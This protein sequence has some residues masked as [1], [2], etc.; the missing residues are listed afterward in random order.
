MTF[1]TLVMFHTC[2]DRQTK[3]YFS[4]PRGIERVE[5]EAEDV[6]GVLPGEQLRGGRLVVHP[7]EL[8]NFV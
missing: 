1:V 8:E 5:G 7:P 2:E 3:A 6:G 4:P